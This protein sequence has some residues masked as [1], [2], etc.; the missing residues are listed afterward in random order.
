MNFFGLTTEMNY[1][2]AILK[3]AGSNGERPNSHAKADPHR[4]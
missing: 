2:I 4:F 3:K 1:E